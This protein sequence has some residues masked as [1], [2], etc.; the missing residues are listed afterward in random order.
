MNKFI[1]TIGCI[2]NLIF[3]SSYPYNF[4]DYIILLIGV[5]LIIVGYD[6]KEEEVE[7]RDKK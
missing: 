6:W 4:F 1:I 7:A 3:I 5:I 2:I